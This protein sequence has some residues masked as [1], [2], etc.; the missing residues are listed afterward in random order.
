MDLDNFAPADADPLM[1]RLAEQYSALTARTDELV[2]ALAHVPDK[3]DEQSIDHAAGFVRQ[4]RAAAGEAEKARKAEG[5]DFLTAKR[6][7]DG[8]FAALAERL[9]KTAAEV[10]RRPCRRRDRRKSGGSWS[11]LRRRGEGA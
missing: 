5:E 10:E 6:T 7:V 4:I 1:D 3:I 8:F 2:E 11:E 9:K